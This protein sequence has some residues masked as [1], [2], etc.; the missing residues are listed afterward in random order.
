MVGHT[1][2][3]DAIRTAVET[4]DTCV[5]DVVEAIRAKGGAV[6]LTADHGNADQ[7]TLDDGSP[8]TAHSMNP[9]Q[10]TLITEDKKQLR[11]SGSLCD[12]A[13]TCLELLGLPQPAEMDGTS[14]IAK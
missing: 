1:G 10:F 6:M 5:H 12:I 9:V 11:A 14:L 4:V 7:I 13:P 2:F 8:M 3:P